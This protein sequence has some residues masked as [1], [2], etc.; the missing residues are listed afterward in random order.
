MFNQI[1]ALFSQF[2]TKSNTVNSEPINKV[3]LVIIIIIDIFILANVFS[4]LDDIS[5]WYLNPSQAYPCYS[6]WQNYHTD[7]NSNQFDKDYNILEYSLQKE[8]NFFSTYQQEE[9]GHLGKVS[10]ICLT[11]AEYKDKVNSSENQQ[12]LNK[13]I[14]KQTQISDLE[15]ANNNIRSQYDSTLLEKIAGQDRNLS[16]NEIEAGKAKEELEKNKRQIT[17]LKEEI[18][19]E[20]TTLIQ[21]PASITLLNF[22]K[23]TGNFTTLK[24]NYERANFWDPSI[25]ILFQLLFLLPLIFVGLSIHNFAQKK[26]Y[27]LMSLMSWHLLV[28]FFIPLVIKVF[29]F[30][31]IGIIFKFFFEIITTLLSGLLFLVSYV[32]I[33]LI[34]VIGFGIIKFF[35]AIIFNPKIQAGK[36][37]EKSKCIR[38]A[39]KIRFQDLYCPHCGYDQYVECANCGNLTYRKLPYCREC[40]SVQNRI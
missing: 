37:I 22:I 14:T 11:Y 36:R 10:P 21:K 6:E 29:Q 4:G 17:V 40:G 19:T 31:Q 3:S 5:R 18:L 20:K 30:L 2:F 35:Q 8:T 16:I 1:K 9:E 26:G 39:R 23:D 28:I 27:G 25:Q 7:S 32:Y 13:I 38:C 12:I 34:P 33:F 15:Q 24:A